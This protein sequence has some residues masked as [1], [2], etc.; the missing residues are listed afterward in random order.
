M[1]S[2]VNLDFSQACDKVVHDILMDKMEKREQN[3][4]VIRSISNWL[5]DHISNR[6]FKSPILSPF[7]DEEIDRG[8]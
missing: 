3:E 7:S 6:L 2:I 5:S 8:K 1:L 4:K